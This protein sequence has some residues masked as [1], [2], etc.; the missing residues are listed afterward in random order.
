MRGRHQRQQAPAIHNSVG[1]RHLRYAFSGQQSPQRLEVAAASDQQQPLVHESNSA[2]APPPLQDDNNNRNNKNARR[3]KRAVGVDSA[4]LGPAF[5]RGSQ[6][7]SRDDISTARHQSS[8]YQCCGALLKEGVVSICLAR[9][10]SSLLAWSI[11][12][13]LS[14]S[15]HTSPSSRTSTRM[16]L[17]QNRNDTKNNRLCVECQLAPPPTRP[18]Q[19]HQQTGQYIQ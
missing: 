13:V 18:V 6:S 14:V 2:L 1:V 9:A 10:S 11:A 19:P 17:W 16:H 15:S 7:T 8:R 5:Q 4:S 12:V 3:S